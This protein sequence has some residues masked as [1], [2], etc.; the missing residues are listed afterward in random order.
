L[1]SLIGFI[2]PLNDPDEEEVGE[3]SFLPTKYYLEIKLENRKNIDLFKEKLENSLFGKF[4]YLN[5]LI[6][7]LIKYLNKLFLYCTKQIYI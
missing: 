5:I 3:G 7:K 1:N 2:S 4:T 6:E